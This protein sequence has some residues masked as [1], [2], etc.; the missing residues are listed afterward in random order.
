MRLHKLLL[1]LSIVFVAILFRE[2]ITHQTTE[3]AFESETLT[4]ESGKTCS[5]CRVYAVFSTDLADL[6]YASV[7]PLTAYIWMH[8]LNVTPIVYMSASSLHGVGQR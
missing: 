6:Q 5:R 1:W 3:P 8:H 2:V 7:A 4:M